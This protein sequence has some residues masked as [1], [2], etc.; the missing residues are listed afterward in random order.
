MLFQFLDERIPGR[1]LPKTDGN[2]NII[3]VSQLQQVVKSTDDFCALECLPFS[4][5]GN[6]VRKPKNL[7]T[8]GSYRICD[9]TR[10]SSS[11]KNNYYLLHHWEISERNSAT[12]ACM[13]PTARSAKIGRQSTSC[14]VF[15]AMARLPCITDGKLR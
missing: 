7:I 11:P 6:R 8:T 10:M 12:I 3:A 2:F 5:W 13:S 1:T 14:A 9:N 4:F 15:S